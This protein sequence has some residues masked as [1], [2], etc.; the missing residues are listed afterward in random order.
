MMRSVESTSPR[1][2]ATRNAT[3]PPASQ[4]AGQFLRFSEVLAKAGT[5]VV[6]SDSGRASPDQMLETLPRDARERKQAE[7]QSAHREAAAQREQSR[8]E[9][10][11]KERIKR[12]DADTNAE[13][14]AADA[15]HPSD[16]GINSTFPIEAKSATRPESLREHP[17]AA[18]QPQ[19]AGTRYSPSE[20]SA[21][22]SQSRNDSQSQSFEARPIAPSTPM[23]QA[24]PTA[25]AA[26]ETGAQ[27]I[28]HV[29][30][31]Q[32]V[33]RPDGASTSTTLTGVASLEG[34]ASKSRESAA[35]SRTPTPGR[36]AEKAESGTPAA[37]TSFERVMRAIRA[38]SGRQTT[39][40]VMLD[41][42]DLGRVHVRVKVAGDRV[43]IGVETENESARELIAQRALRLKSALEEQGLRVDRFEITTQQSGL[44]DARASTGQESAPLRRE[45]EGQRPHEKS[46]E[47][48]R[49]QSDR[50]EVGRL[51]PHRDSATS[52]WT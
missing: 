19:E 29:L 4:P 25:A 26:R 40:R 42:P 3:T 21:P 12:A 8:A 22:V 33:G 20:E 45:P 44:F 6:Q 48:F 30:T 41:P 32:G 47:E 23:A 5:S 2:S 46:K 34:N 18:S 37:P 15:P 10:R 24:A 14:Q 52:I 11:M 27:E 36:A 39:A 51:G 9:G 38:Q 49:D 43:D 31:L 28:A 7:L 16:A 50:R 13:P 17:V 1:T 35:P